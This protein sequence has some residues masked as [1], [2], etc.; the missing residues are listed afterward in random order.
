[1]LLAFSI[2]NFH[3]ET[4]PQEVVQSDL[5]ITSSPDYLGPR[6]LLPLPLRYGGF[7]AGTSR[8]G[9]GRVLLKLRGSREN[10]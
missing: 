8:P 2:I 9:S 4:E 10:F 6:I 5:Q 1:M 7:Q 3:F